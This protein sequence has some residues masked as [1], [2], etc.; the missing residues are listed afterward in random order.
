MS[1]ATPPPLSTPHIRL[2]T[3][4]IHLHPRMLTS[5]PP[6]TPLPVYVT[7]P[8]I[9]AAWTLLG[10]FRLA[11]ALPADPETVGLKDGGRRIVLG[12]YEPIKDGLA[13]SYGLRWQS[14]VLE[15][16]PDRGP[17]PA[18]EV[19]PEYLAGHAPAPETYADSWYPS[20]E[21]AA[22]YGD[23]PRNGKRAKALPL[24]HPLPALPAAAAPQSAGS[25]W[26]DKLGDEP[27]ITALPAADAAQTPIAGS[28]AD[29]SGP[30]SESQY[31]TTSGCE[32][33]KDSGDESDNWSVLSDGPVDRQWTVVFDEKEELV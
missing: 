13:S 16:V 1:A 12:A 32:S 7:A 20:P 24:P 6:H 26:M 11:T 14:A 33:E 4:Y 18:D 8:D 15:R 28:F 22:K 29:I 23:A 10:T 31:S 25:L 17:A 5:L 27:E 3:S 21:L 9:P 2:T 30:M 19:P